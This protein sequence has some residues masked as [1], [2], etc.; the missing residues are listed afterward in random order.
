MLE[1]QTTVITTFIAG[2]F[3][4][5]VAGDRT[6]QAEDRLADLLQALALGVALGRTDG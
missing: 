4:R 5:F 1:V 2:V 3:S 6:V